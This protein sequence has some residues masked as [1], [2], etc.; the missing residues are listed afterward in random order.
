MLVDEMGKD[1]PNGKYFEVLDDERKEICRLH[2]L[3]CNTQY[4]R[5][6][7]MLFVTVN[8]AISLLDVAVKVVC[9]VLCIMWPYSSHFPSCSLACMCGVRP[10]ASSRNIIQKA[11][12]K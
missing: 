1:Q 11:L 5:R 2:M 6:D 12:E 10:S 7:V 8:A 9:C 4:V 3:Y